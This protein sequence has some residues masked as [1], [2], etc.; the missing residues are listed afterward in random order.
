MKAIP[1][2]DTK[3]EKK[4][5][6]LL[7]KMGLRFR[8]DIEPVSGFRCKADIVFRKVRVC[9]FID[10]CFWH[11]CPIHF[12]PPKTNRDWWEEKIKD[13]ILRDRKKTILIK[14]NGWTVMRFWEH[15]LKDDCIGEIS[16]KIYKLVK[17]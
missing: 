4:L 6:S 17:K 10:G 9:I 2:R 16:K 12:K 1:S 15:E 13:N 8:K 14:K 7:H 11:G 3:P 5:R